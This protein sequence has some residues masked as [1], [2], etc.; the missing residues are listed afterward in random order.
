MSTLQ[1]NTATN[2][3]CG[4]WTDF[5]IL[6]PGTVESTH[7]DNIISYIMGTMVPLNQPNEVQVTPD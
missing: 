5:E 3:H 4:F 1:I 6:C 2:M 7:A